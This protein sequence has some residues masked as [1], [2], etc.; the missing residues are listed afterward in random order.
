MSVKVRPYR[1]GG[2]EVDIT[3]R[4][5]N[6][7]PYRDRRTVT[8]TSKSAALRWGE[9]RERHLLVNGVEDRQ[10][11]VPT[12]K[13]F[14]SRFLEGHARANRQKPSGIAAKESIL[15]LHLVPALGTKRLDAI[16]SEDVQRLKSRLVTRSPKT[17]NNVLTVLNTLLKK[18]VEWDVIEQVPC[19]IRLLPAPKGT[20]PFH[21]F[22][23]FEKL[24]KG[25][26]AIDRR[27]LLLVL[28]GGEAGLRLGE[29]MAL[30][31][32]HVDLDKRQVCVAE[33]DWKGRV[34]V[35]KGGTIRYVGMTARLERTLRAHR[36]LRGQRVVCQQDGQPL[37][38]KI[39]QQAVGRAAR[40]ANVE[41]GVHIL[42]HTFCSH[43][44]MRGASVLQIQ[45]LAGHKELSTT[46]RYMH[47]SP[48]AEAAAI[49]LLD[50]PAPAWAR[51]DILET[52]AGGDAKLHE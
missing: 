44:A 34:T 17:V 47:L 50:E 21:D 30:R 6:G 12:L 10:Q 4:L 23:A 28:L 5:P 38:M 46:M 11:E 18:A 43:L 25:A 22:G 26:E 7:T 42:R 24:V 41:E 39:I 51:G 15:R 3:I 45:K 36:H 1:R 32:K 9:A 49:R 14:E 16:T 19:T 29:M 40:R 37:T 20:P 52:A 31:W 8:T 48:A 33:S 2:W 27:T 13:E 35:P